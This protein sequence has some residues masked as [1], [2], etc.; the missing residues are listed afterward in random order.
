MSYAKHNHIINEYAQRSAC[1]MVDTLA[2]V[3]LSIQ[4]TWYGVGDQMADWREH[5][6]HSKFVWGGKAEALA[7]ALENKYSLYAEAM[8]F[9]DDPAALMAVFLQVPNLG[10]VKAGF[11]CQL[12]SGGVGCLD[13][14]NL[15]NYNVPKGLTTY[16]KGATAKTR[17]RKISEYVTWCAKRRSEFLWNRWCTM[18]AEKYPNRFADAEHVS[19]SHVEYLLGGDGNG[20]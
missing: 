4:Q 5:G 2:M 13:L 6:I 7:Y 10:L 16:N 11:M 1:N 18:V 9:K 15:R 3:Q 19:A 14:H 20:S 12:F 8:E 17:T